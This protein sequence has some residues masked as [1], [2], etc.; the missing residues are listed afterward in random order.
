MVMAMATG[1][2][3]TP[4][5]AP[6]PDTALSVLAALAERGVSLHAYDGRLRSSGPPGAID[7]ALA[8][9]LRAQRSVIEAALV[10][11][12]FYP[13]N[14]AH[15]QATAFWQA[16]EAAV[17]D[18]PRLAPAPQLRLDEP[19]TAIAIGPAPASRL[20]AAVLFTLWRWT[21][22]PAVA[23]R[24]RTRTGALPVRIAPSPHGSFAA[25]RAD[26]LRAW[27]AALRMRGAGAA[28]MNAA[29]ASCQV[30]IDLRRHVPADAGP[31]D[32]DAQAPWLTFVRAPMQGPHRWM[33]R[34]RMAL[35]DATQATWFAGAVADCLAAMAGP[36]MTRGAARE[37]AAAWSAPASCPVGHAVALPAVSIAGEIARRTALTPGAPALVGGGRRLDYRA[38][39]RAANALARRLL[40]SGARPGAPLAIL[41]ERGPDVP[42]CFLAALKAGLCLAPLDPDWPVERLADVLERLA[43]ALVVVDRVRADL[44]LPQVT[45]ADLTPLDA[46]F[47]EHAAPDHPVYIVHTSGT[48][49]VPK[50]ALNVQRGL[51]NRLLFMNRY[52]GA[53]A[54]ATVLQTTPH[55]FDSALWQFFWPWMNGGCCVVEDAVA[56]AWAASPHAQLLEEGVRTVD[57]TPSRLRAFLDEVASDH[58]LALRHVIVGGELL[59]GGVIAAFR[60]RLPGVRLHNFYGPSETSIGVICADVTDVAPGQPVPIGRPIDNVFVRVV[61]PDGAV[62]PPGAVGELLIGGACVG[63]GYVGDPAETAR[64]FIPDPVAGAA[65]TMYRS[66]DLVRCLA[67]GSLQCL[68]RRDG[69]LKL[70]GLR[71]ESQEIR[72]VLEACPVIAQA[73]VALRGQDEHA[74]LVAYVVLRG[75]M[76]PPAGWDAPLRLALAARLPR[77]MVPGAIVALP[78]LP[79]R[80]SGK[81][82][83]TQLPDPID[84]D[85]GNAAPPGGAGHGYRRA[86]AALWSDVLGG[87]SISED[88]DFFALGGHS[89]LAARL[90]ARIGTQ[91]GIAVPLRL[92]LAEPVLGR[93]TDAVLRGA[94]GAA[95][96][97]P[98]P[99]RRAGAGAP[100]F[101]VHGGDGEL[102]YAR[103]LAAELEPGFPV[104]GFGA[105]GLRA[106]ETP[107]EGGPA[108]AADYVAALRAIQPHG[109]YRL[110]GW[111]AGGAIACEMARQLEACA[112]PV[113]LVI[114][115]DT[116]RYRRLDAATRPAT[117]LAA[118]LE[119]L[120]ALSGGAGSD[121]G[122]L[123]GADDVQGWLARGRA[124]GW[125][126]GDAGADE[127]ERV[128][129]VRLALACAVHSHDG[130]LP[131]CTVVLAVAAAHA[132]RYLGWGVIPGWHR[133]DVPGDHLSMVTPV[134]AP[135]LA[136]ALSPFLVSPSSL[137]ESS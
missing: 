105:A 95:C 114:L 38:L 20:L 12:R 85:R 137:T 83:E 29:G 82:D 49:G 51:L 57:F 35:F 97:N 4:A 81:V 62:L 23:L 2:E 123:P 56:G 128:L 25:L 14:H 102:T 122:S 88:D 33:M 126:H 40:D 79:L 127:A 110:G 50:A 77:H 119:Q 99:L 93:F 76:P 64:V 69:Q 136:R 67:D 27:R 132:D 112:E 7:A 121:A 8:S 113:E 34:H 98:V 39:D 103:H 59:S 60:A 32:G 74:R 58:G 120:R 46:T 15:V 52:F 47:E 94:S 42:V 72:H 129:A 28:L 1:R 48:T 18:C 117:T 66:G 90:I 89:L 19:A 24:V 17:R 36:A 43:P 80:S 104:Y 65:H 10:D 100:L 22:G 61:D 63:A 115:I 21:G 124:A 37:G 116:P 131:S 108:L 78:A 75:G 118:R 44:A 71:I 31:P 130:A 135:A 3:T 101:L 9:R 26:V 45:C 109:P 54:A 11:G 5:A 96:P 106:G 91:F 133:V 125:L 107:V 55:W 68:G 30:E 87:A 84:P 13:G 70:R 16:E 134:H 86:M 73:H 92:L 111:S 41:L 53:D 6:L